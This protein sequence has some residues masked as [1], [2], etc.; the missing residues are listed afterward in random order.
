MKIINE[1]RI[2]DFARKVNSTAKN[3]V[4]DIENTL[5]YYNG[6]RDSKFDYKSKANDS[7]LEKT[8]LGADSKGLKYQ[9]K[10]D[11]RRNMVQ[12]QFDVREVPRSLADRVNPTKKSQNS[13]VQYITSYDEDSYTVTM[14]L[15][16]SD[17]KDKDESVMTPTPVP[18]KGQVCDKDGIL[19]PK[20][21][22]KVEDEEQESSLVL[23]ESQIDLDEFYSELKLEL[24]APEESEEVLD[25][26][27]GLELSIPEVV[28]DPVKGDFLEIKINNKIYRYELSDSS[29]KTVSDVARTVTGIQKHSDGRALAY[30]KKN[31]KLVKTTIEESSSF[32]DHHICQGC[33]KPLSQCTCEVQEEDID[34][35]NLE[36]SSSCQ[37]VFKIDGDTFDQ[38]CKENQLIQYIR[39]DQYLDFRSEFTK[40]FSSF[41]KAVDSLWNFDGN[42]EREYYSDLLKKYLQDNQKIDECTQPS[43]VGQHK[44]DSI[45]II[46]GCG[47]EEEGTNE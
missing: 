3:V 26:T 38:M 43:S 42:Y 28:T 15:P 12:V 2:S 13:L 41:D 18:Y 20:D 23:K 39:S 6:K 1:G 47:N 10:K 32:K 44:T 46:E 27:A 30:L 25:E 17:S 14:E 29:D 4:D 16:M 36:E 24:D 22:A 11:D 37:I 35:D 45:D 31:M 9:A 34:F 7:D 40:G 5:D 8:P 33:G 21:S 19:I